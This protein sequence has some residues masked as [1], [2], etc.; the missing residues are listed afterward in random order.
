MASAYD[1]IKP[2]INHNPVV[3]ATYGMDVYIS[4]IFTDN[5]G[6]TESYLYYRVKGT[7]IY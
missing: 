6:I 4:G 2:I 3:K 1:T 7:D 5:V